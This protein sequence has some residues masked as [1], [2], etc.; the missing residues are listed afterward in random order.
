MGVFSEKIGNVSLR[1]EPTSWRVISRD[2]SHLIAEIRELKGNSAAK[3]MYEIVFLDMSKLQCKEYIVD[4]YI[5]VFQYDLYDGYM[6]IIAK[7]H[8]EPHEGLPKLQTATEPFHM[9]VKADE[10]DY[11]ASVRKELPE[12][13]RTVEGILV[14]I[15]NSASLKYLY[16]T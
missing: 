7:F 15:E 13:L 16:T 1:L 2:F 4:G 8:S 9:H 3:A 14:L 5:D 6:N 10:K 12:T 11:A